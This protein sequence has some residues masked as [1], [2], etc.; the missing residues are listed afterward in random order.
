M[1]LQSHVQHQIKRSY[2]NEPIDLSF[3]PGEPT[4][5]KNEEYGQALAETYPWKYTVVSASG[6]SQATVND[7]AKLENKPTKEELQNETVFPI[8]ALKALADKLEISYSF[9]IGRTT[10]A[11]RLISAIY[12]E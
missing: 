10:L 11:D 8:E 7:A 5:V 1:F 9:N 12:P 3:V 4:E 2:K 6:E